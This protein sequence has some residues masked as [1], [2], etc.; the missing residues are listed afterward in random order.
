MQM[1]EFVATEKFPRVVIPVQAG[2]QAADEMRH[3]GAGRYPLAAWGKLG[4]P[5]AGV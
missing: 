1:E 5:L 3:T 4:Y 2:I